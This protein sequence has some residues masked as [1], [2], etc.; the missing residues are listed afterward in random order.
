MAI[1]LEMSPRIIQN[2]AN[3]YNDTHRIFMEYIDNSLDSAEDCYDRE[4]NEYNR[5]IKITLEISGSDFKNGFVT[6]TDNCEGIAKFTEVVQSIGSSIK[7]TQFSTN[8]Q[9][10]F[11][12]YSFMAACEKLE[13]TS[14]AKEGNAYYLPILRS[15]FDESK[16]ENVVFPDPKVVN[17]KIESGTKIIL[18]EFDK[19]MWKV[20][21]FEMI[22]S[23]IEK[24]FELLLSRKNLQIKLVKNGREEICGA[25]DY[26]SLEGEVW[27]DNISYLS[28]YKGT[29][30]PQ[31]INF[32]LQSS[33]KVFLKITKGKNIDKSP[34]F[35]IKGRRIA[36]VREV[37]SFKTTHRGE[38]WGHPNL[39]GYID[40]G[41][42]LSPNIARTDFSVKGI[43]GIKAKAVFA[44]LFKLEDVILEFLSDLN[45]KSDAKH[46]KELED[47]LNKTLSKLA[48]M[49]NMNFRTELITGKTANAR[50]TD[51]KVSSIPD[52]IDSNPTEQDEKYF[53]GEGKYNWDG[54]EDP[55]KRTETDLSKNEKESETDSPEESD[56]PFDDDEKIGS[57][58][59]KSGFN[60]EISD[61]EPDIDIETK[62]E[63]RSNLIGGT[64]II[65]RKHKDFM[66]RVDKKRSG[67]SKIT[68]RLITYMAGE[69]T[70]HYKDK[71]ITREGQPS[72]NKKMFNSVVQFIYKFEDL[73]NGLIGKNLGD[74]LNE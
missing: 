62:E 51:V 7:R 34:V 47:E 74:V 15:Q 36:E 10:G 39:T 53:D 68:Q 1:K 22:K 42:F 16:Q 50:K 21:N 60:I 63:L 52:E 28:S 5:P 3:L 19:E 17:F 61:R 57:E 14:K 71:Y 11:G 30:A 65:F 8:G 18:S 48:R 4:K 35:I 69:I 54:N 9:F 20:I 40:L 23:E 24:H 6:I 59:K 25:F 38:L 12:V 45:K 66:D 73:L 2:V 72:Y 31:E 33:I 70:V 32:K 29:K 44:E 27:E 58:K 55:Q 26:S 41:G 67:E 49:D 56:N 46:Y 43:E 13:I 37:K 64:I